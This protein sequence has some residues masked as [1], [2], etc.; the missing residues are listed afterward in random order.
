MSTR[1]PLIALERVGL[2]FGDRAP[3]LQ[4]VSLRVASGE[5]LALIGASGCG[6][7]TLLR[8]L[9][10]LQP[11]SAGKIAR[12][13]PESRIGIV[14]QDATLMP[15]A[16][17]FDNVALPLRLHRLPRAARHERVMAA[18]AQVGLGDRAAARPHELSGGMKMRVALARAL[19][20]EPAL[21]LLDEPFAALDEIT[22]LRLSDDLSALQA[23]LG[24]AVVFVTH[25]VSESVAL[26]DRVLV[27]ARAPGRIMAQFSIDA[28]HPRH[29]EFRQSSAYLGKVEE[30]SAALRQTLQAG[31][32][33]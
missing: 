28:P 9:A 7:S 10:G 33:L 21:L 18:L 5:F 1:T 23:R 14:F 20:V 11:P 2:G 17:A 8:V 24:M 32:D 6:K 22:R 16:S 13:Q 19:V 30:V 15:W 31:D 4:D 3:V 26:A 12:L 27:M 29:H 25:A